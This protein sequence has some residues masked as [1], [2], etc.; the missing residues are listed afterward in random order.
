MNVQLRLHSCIS[1]I[2]Y[3]DWVEKETEKNNH[4]ILAEKSQHFLRGKDILKQ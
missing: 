3:S 1:L 2:G 4:F